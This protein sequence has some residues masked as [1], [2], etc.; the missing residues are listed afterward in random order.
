MMN[1]VTNNYDTL[2]KNAKNTEKSKLSLNVNTMLHKSLKT[3]INLHLR[4]KQR[5]KILIKVYEYTIVN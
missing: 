1:A 4:A 3:T 5:E 2:Q